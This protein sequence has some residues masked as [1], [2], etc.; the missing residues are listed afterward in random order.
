MQSQSLLHQVKS[1]KDCIKEIVMR[2]LLTVSIPSSSGQ[3]FQDQDQANVHDDLEAS[4][5]LLHQVKSSKIKTP[6]KI[7]FRKPG[8]NPFF[9]RSSLPRV[10]IFSSFV[11]VGYVCIF[12]NLL[13][14]SCFSPPFR[15]CCW[16]WLSD[17]PVKSICFARSLT[18]HL[19]RPQGEIQ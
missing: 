12:Y 2:F 19:G 8:L 6:W 15:C 16:A 14:S 4:Q 13:F 7:L 9:I 10:S 5:S 11:S 18:S 17:L 1:S 3:V